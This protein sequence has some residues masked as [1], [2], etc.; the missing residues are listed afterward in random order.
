MDWIKRNLA[1]VISSVFALALLGGAGWYLYKGVSRNAAALDA[2]NQEY[3]TL[4]RL[5][6]QNP[7]PGNDKIDNIAAA[8]AQEKEVRAFSQKVRQVFRPIAPIPATA[9]PNNAQFAEGLRRTLDRLQR[10]ANDA[11]VQLPE[12]YNFSFTAIRP[13]LVFDQAG[14]APLA[15]Q[16]GEVKAICDVLFAA[17]INALDNIRR[18]RVATHDREAPQL[19]DY[20]DRAP[21]T[22]D[23]AVLAPY[24]V[25]LRCFSSELGA[26]LAGF[27]SSRSGFLV[28]AINVEPALATGSFLDPT[29]LGGELPQPGFMP[30]PGGMRPMPGGMPGGEFGTGGFRPGLPGAY[31]Q[32]QPGGQPAPAPAGTRGGLPVLLDEK[33][34]KATLLIEVVRLNPAN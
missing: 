14:L 26:V 11:G 27:A 10:E 4:E 3:S 8:R 13:L 20:T 17:K 25:S 2:L 6:R 22:N 1:F 18:V 29:M 31:G 9:N 34:F 16:V 19:T 28:K 23:V 21:V 24:E 32:P 5:N 7:H 30:Q 15:Q 12:K 33:Q